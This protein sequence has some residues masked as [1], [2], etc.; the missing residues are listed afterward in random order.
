[1]RKLR[2]GTIVKIFFI[3]AI[4]AGT[5]LGIRQGKEDFVSQVFFLGKTELESCTLENLATCSNY[6]YYFFVLVF[7]GYVFFLC[8]TFLRKRYSN[9]FLTTTEEAAIEK[10]SA[11]DFRNEY[12]KTNKTRLLILIGIGIL[13]VIW[14]FTLGPYF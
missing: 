7:W 9:I 1:M 5:F 10:K 2:A 3:L 13:V 14:A 11:P 4:A 6:L 12:R 8:A